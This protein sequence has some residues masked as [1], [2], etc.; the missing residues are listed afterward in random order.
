LNSDAGG[1]EFTHAVEP[2]LR[3]FL[4]NI[5]NPFVWMPLGLFVL[6]VPAYPI[7]RLRVFVYLAIAFM[8]LTFGA[9][10]VGRWHNRQTPPQPDP[11]APSYRSD[12]AF[13]TRRWTCWTPANRMRRGI[14][15]IKEIDTALEL[16]G[17]NYP[18][19]EH[20]RRLVEA[21]KKGEIP[22]EFFEVRVIDACKL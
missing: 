4:E 1:G 5:D 18:D 2:I 3:K 15:A 8:A 13:N 14:A 6:C 22:F 20:D 17:G 10:W 19:A 7:T 21:V 11:Q 16:T 9:D 12:R